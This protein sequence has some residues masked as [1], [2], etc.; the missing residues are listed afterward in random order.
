MRRI[1][2]PVC[3]QVEWRI[4]SNPEV[5]DLYGEPSLVTEIKRNRLRWLGHLERLP[6]QR[7][8]KRVYMLKPEGNRR[9]GRPRKRWLDD[10]EED[11]RSLGVSGWRN[12]ALD[13][14]GWRRVVEESKALQ[15]P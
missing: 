4:R 1:Y 13:R 15:G 14:E 3:D 7:A 9:P 2:G 5:A 10:V 6:E 12:R 8:V 11:L